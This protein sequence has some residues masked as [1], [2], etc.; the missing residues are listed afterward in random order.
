MS[1][2]P[3]LPSTMV[4]W[5]LYAGKR[6]VGKPQIDYANFPH[7]SNKTR[8]EHFP[9]MP[10][11]KDNAGKVLVVNKA[12]DA[13]ELVDVQGNLA[14]VQKTLTD[15]DARLDAA[16]KAETKTRTDAVVKLDADITAEEKARKVAVTALDTKTDTAIK[17]EVKARTDACNKLDA[18][19]TAEEKARAAAITALDTKTDTAIKAEVKA[20]TDACNKLDADITAEEKARTD[21]N[22]ALTVQLNTKFDTAQKSTTAVDVKVN[23][24]RTDFNNHVTAQTKYN[25]DTTNKINDVDKNA[26]SGITATQTQV[27]TL[28]KR[29][30]DTG[31]QLYQDMVNVEAKLTAVDA[32]TAETNKQQDQRL[33]KI[34]TDFA[35]KAYVQEE[36]KKISITDIKQVQA[37]ANLPKAETA[38]GDFYF[39]TSTKEWKTSDGKA[40]L[41]VTAVVPDEVQARFNKLQSDLEAKIIAVEKNAKTA[42]AWLK[43]DGYTG[44]NLE[45][46]AS[47]NTINGMNPLDF[48]SRSLGSEIFKPITYKQTIF[49]SNDELV[50]KGY[51]DTKDAAFD[52]AAKDAAQKAFNDAKAYSDKQDAETDKVAKAN[53]DKVLVD[54]KAY[55]DA[56]DA[57][58]TKV[59]TDT[60]TK[61]VND[62]KAYSDTKD[63][64]QTKVITDTFTKAVNDSKAY[65]DSKDTAQTKAV[66]DAFT[67]AVQDSKAY[68][69]LNDAKCVQKAG[70]TLTGSLTAPDFIQSTPQTN[71][72][73]ASTRKDYVDA[74][75]KAVDAKNFTYNR[76][77][78]TV[79]LN[80]LGSSD[81]AGV[82]PQPANANATTAN[83]Y[84]EQQAGC[85][86]VN[87]SAYGCQQEYTTFASGNKY[88]RGLAG[89]WNGKDGPWSPWKCITPD[90]TVIKG[91]KGDAGATGPQGPAG[92]AGKNGVDGKAG[93][94][95]ANGAVGPKGDTGPQGPMGPQGAKGDE[96]DKGDTG[97]TGPQGPAG[98][99][100][101]NG[102]NG[103]QGPQGP[104]GADGE[105]GAKNA[106]PL[107][108]GTLTGSVTFSTDHQLVWSRNTDTAKIGFKNTADA[109][110]DSYM[111]FET[112]DNGNEYFKF[113][114]NT[115]GKIAEWARITANGMDIAGSTV[116]KYFRTDELGGTDTVAPYASKSQGGAF[117]AMYNRHATFHTDVTQTGS[118]YAPNTSVKYTH[119][120][121]WGG[122]YSTGVLNTGAA[123]SG[124]YC[125]HHINSA[126][127][128]PQMWSFAG[129]TGL[130]TSPKIST[131]HLA[132][133]GMNIGGSGIS[134]AGGI[135]I[136]NSSPTIVLQD[137]DHMGAVLH[138]NSNLFYVLRTPTANNGAFDGGPNGRHPMTLNLANGDVV[139]SGNI[140][141]YSDLRLKKDV[142]T[143][144]NALQSVMQLR[145]VLYKRIGTDT[146]R[147]ECGFIAQELETVIPEVVQTQQDEM[148][149]KTVDYAKLVAYMAGAI[150]ELQAQINELRAQQGRA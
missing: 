6:E 52:K 21:A 55:A 123:S 4:F 48:V 93:V 137:T 145:P 15:T 13:V 36:I 56:K 108:G 53:A 2:I 63:A 25:T 131:S 106:L 103:A 72:A 94:N 31:A 149:T 97:A 42:H 83:N 112:G 101:V 114:G 128:E 45:L 41:D 5:Q 76:S 107:T 30:T 74:Q 121:G 126:G 58:Q 80:T 28:D 59:I 1:D 57:E 141:S 73:A 47:L 61:A 26:Q 110:T 8:A 122:M 27:Q 23:T 144:E 96:G 139:F 38:Y 17:A 69:D 150:Q 100:G 51:V 146:D 105:D 50:N 147:V 29:L 11:W 62:S 54:A 49:A 81:H 14:K 91:E 32:K 118:N 75:I 34:E 88:I 40:W 37:E 127:G 117:A 133:D 12:G 18:D 44:T 129:A 22:N 85:L 9:D 60:F 67:K 120:S 132:V 95:G 16:I 66:T 46:A 19:I 124:S 111:W 109:D 104:K 3:N 98:K 79:N 116:S 39:I 119:N 142:K 64:E 87:P 102:T 92:A 43:L 71:N 35:T 90:I 20:R 68:S 89:A 84:P 130:F 7:L 125:I 77:A 115:S 140:G 65:S 143:L 134:S 24:Q 99:N 78:L 70:D 113:Q 138:N 82:Y 33:A 86:Q 136:N 148:Q 10:N 135:T